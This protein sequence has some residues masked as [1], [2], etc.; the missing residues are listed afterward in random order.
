SHAISLFAGDRFAGWLAWFQHS[1]SPAM[2]WRERAVC[3]Q[4]VR[5]FSLE[6]N[7]KIGIVLDQMLQSGGGFQQSLSAIRQLVRICPSDIS[8]EIFT[9]TPSN[10]DHPQLMSMRVHVVRRGI[11]D[12]IKVAAL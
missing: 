2:A 3:R 8:I 11:V 6:K 10:V 4:L 9:T 7:M 12:R 5:F 1:V